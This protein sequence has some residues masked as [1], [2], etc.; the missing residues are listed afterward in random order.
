MFLKTNRHRQEID[1]Q[2]GSPCLPFQQA[3]WHTLLQLGLRN[4][5]LVAMSMYLLLSS[6]GMHQD[7]TPSAVGLAC[8]DCPRA[9]ARL[10]NNTVSLRASSTRQSLFFREKNQTCTELRGTILRHLLPPMK[11]WIHTR[12]P[13]EIVGLPKE[14]GGFP[15][16]EKSQFPSRE[17][18][19]KATQNCNHDLVHV[20]FSL[21][22]SATP[23]TNRLHQNNINSK[24]SVLG[25]GEGPDEIPLNTS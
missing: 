1:W 21:I 18:G 9:C 19:A 7:E 25:G 14:R 13:V 16:P 22:L 6:I 15:V 4:A 2:N 17:R 24:G 20:W 11:R 23:W 8:K 12:D 3:C 10:S 5:P